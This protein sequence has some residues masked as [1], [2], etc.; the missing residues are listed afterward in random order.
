VRGRADAPIVCPKNVLLYGASTRSE[1]RVPPLD[2]QADVTLPVIF[3]RR[4]QEDKIFK[5]LRPLTA[6]F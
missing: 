4:R 5:K 6:G 2:P 3:V 1:F